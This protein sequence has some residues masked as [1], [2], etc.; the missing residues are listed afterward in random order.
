MGL[1]R[2]PEIKQNQG[3]R[4]RTRIIKS[5][6]IPFEKYL[7]VG[8]KGGMGFVSAP[9]NS[10]AVQAFKKEFKG[11]LDDPIGLLEQVGQFLGSNTYT[12]DKMQS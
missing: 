8:C 1:A 12:W 7:W 10:S 5:G 3:V 6:Y 9:L 4:M 2:I 11:L